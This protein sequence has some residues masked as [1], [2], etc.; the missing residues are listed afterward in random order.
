MLRAGRLKNAPRDYSCA[1]LRCRQ[2]VARSRAVAGSRAPSVIESCFRSSKVLPLLAFLIATAALVFG[3]LT[4]SGAAAAAVVGTVALVAGWRWAG[5]LLLFFVIGTSASRFREQRK[6]TLTENI[7]AKRGAR[8]AWQVVAN[9]G[10]FAVCAFVSQYRP[11]QGWWWA[12]CGALAAAMADSLATELGTLS[13][14]APRSLL[15][16][17]ELPVGT[18]GGVTWTG[19]LAGALGALLLAV[20]ASI[21]A[22]G[23]AAGA[24]VLLTAG[25]AGSLADSA[26]GATIQ[27]RRWCEKCQSSTERTVH[28]CGESTV[29][30]GGIPWLDNDVVNLMSTLVG[31]AVGAAGAWLV[32]A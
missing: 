16:G 11:E 29:Q 15:G 23:G 27:H 7:I 21:V 5:A 30:A 2:C 18:S 25:I 3:A 31:A 26:L 32:V 24:L 8:D 14:S 1:A 10:V 6:A 22:G 28:T 20:P 4:P 13:G 12:A 9:G 17:R 19:T